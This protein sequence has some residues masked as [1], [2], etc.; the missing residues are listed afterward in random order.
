M[1]TAANTEHTTDELLRVSH[2]LEEGI[3]ENLLEHFKRS[4]L[5]SGYDYWLLNDNRGDP[6]VWLAFN[7]RE[8]VEEFGGVESNEE[9]TKLLI[10]ASIYL[11]TFQTDGYTIAVPGP[12][13]RSYEDPFFYPIHVGF[14]DGWSDSEYH[15]YQKFEELIS[16]YD[17]SPAEALDYWV[18]TQ[19][20]KESHEWA[21]VRGVQTEAIRK[22]VRQARD[23]LQDEELGASHERENIRAVP[24]DE[25]PSGEP[26]DSDKDIFYVPTEESTT[27]MG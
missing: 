20:G 2:E 7:K 16:R 17:F 26:H 4:R 12:V 14:P 3:Q 24:V 8:L 6:G 23:K 25:I 10:I 13:A 22:N 9:Y 11:D 18:S 21:G 1:E 27:S 15:T 5:R 19:I